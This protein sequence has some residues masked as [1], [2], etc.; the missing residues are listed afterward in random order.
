MGLFDGLEKLGL[1]AKKVENLYG[2][3]KKAPDQQAAETAAGAPAVKVP[4]KEFL[5]W[6]S[7][8]CPLCDQTFRT[9]APRSG[10]VRRLAPDEDLRPR[11]DG[12]DTL[13]Y[14][15]QVCPRC[16][17]AA[18]NLSIYW[19]HETSG[20]R[21]LIMEQVCEDFDPEPIEDAFDEEETESWS[22]DLAVMLHRLSLY[23][24]TVKKAK[25]SEVAYNCLVL[26]WLLRGQAEE[27]EGQEE[28][29]QEKIAQ[30]R[31][32]EKT[33]YEQAFEGLQKAMT[34]ESFPICGMDATTYDFL[35]ATMAKRLGQYDTASK[36][37][38]QIL[39]NQ[40]V[41]PRIKD[42]ARDLKDAILAAKKAAG[43]Q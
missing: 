19:G 31:E 24:A 39:T 6:K 9:M 15:A 29:D 18:L 38:G 41:N 4:E 22:Y 16:G 37:V 26:S 27:E 21:R 12:V 42:K 43:A 30:I 3:T 33:Y 14:N 36:I 13:K 32:E 35:V 7:V 1:R 17:Y 8:K 5:I 28:P 23:V 10:K 11:S 34:S 20:Q 2:E 40:Q 25:T